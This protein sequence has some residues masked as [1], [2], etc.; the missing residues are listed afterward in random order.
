MMPDLK[1]PNSLLRALQLGTSTKPT[2]ETLKRQRVSFI[3]GALKADSSVT[4]DL[5]E[6]VLA[7]QEG[8]KG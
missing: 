3:L 5:V 1:T 8:R 4:R 7:V 6:H 2:E